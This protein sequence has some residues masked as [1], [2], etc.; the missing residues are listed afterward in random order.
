[1]KRI[2]QPFFRL[3]RGS[4][5][6]IINALASAFG[7]DLLF[8]AYNNMGILKYENE[9][10]TGEEYFISDFFRKTIGGTGQYVF[11]DVGANIG[12]YSG[13][14]V[15]EY[16]GSFVYSF[17]PNQKTFEILLQNVSGKAKCINAGLGAEQKTAR[18]Y[19]YSDSVA[20]SHA[21]IYGEVFSTFHKAANV[22]GMDVKMTTIDSFCEE[23]KISHIDLLKID[24]EGNELQVLKGA[25]RMISEDRIKVI[26]FEF[27]ECNVFSR[28]FL[29]DFYDILQNYRIYRLDS[30]RAIPLF[31]YDSTN[32][33]FRFQ[34]FIAVSKRLKA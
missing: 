3:G 8:L 16:P 25:T 21:S 13:M 5:K 20:S 30:R 33:I 18:L 24:T 9:Q 15:K 10:V 1:M 4:V 7:V 28:V 32:E 19:T 17:E 12:K 29:R 31:S 6:K 23:E 34:N 14:L 22:I 2:L 11:F 27:G 26:Q